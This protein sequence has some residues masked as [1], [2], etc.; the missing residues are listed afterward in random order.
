MEHTRAEKMQLAPKVG[1]SLL[2][3][4]RRAI[5]TILEV[6]IYIHPCTLLHRLPTPDLGLP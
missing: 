1:D 6:F 3:N 2:S 5:L 4:Q